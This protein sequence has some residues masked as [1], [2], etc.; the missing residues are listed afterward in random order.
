MQVEV[1]LPNSDGAL[2]PGAYVQVVAAAAGEPGAD[3]SRPTRC[4]S[5]AKARASRSSTPTA[6]VHLRPVTL[7]RNYGE[8]VEVLDGVDGERPAR[9]QPA[10]L[11]RRRRRGRGRRR[12]G[13]APK[14]AQVTRARALRAAPLRSRRCS[15]RAPP[16]PTTSGR[17]STCRWRGRSRRRG[18][19]ARPSDA[20]RKG[21]WWQRFGDPQL[22]ALEQQA[23]AGNPTLA[24]ASARLAQAR[25]TLAVGVGRRCSRRSASAC[26]RRALQDLR[27][28]AAHQLQLAATSRRSR[29]TSSLALDGQLRGRPRR[30]RAAHDRRRARLGRAVGGRP[31]E[32][33]AA[34][35]RRPRDRLL[36]PARDRHRARRAGALDRAAAARARARRPRGTTSA[37][38]RASTSRSS[39]R[40]STTR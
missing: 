31:R 17:R 4:C 15:R 13:A 38:P 24:A 18:A 20:R 22:D 8:T 16:G 25:A 12:R 23:L 36:Q 14:D 2:L 30:P 34:A 21:P 10:R 33:A 32:R 40:C 28:P 11:A 39:R 37:P 27:E 3:R 9:A 19:K 6:R 26:A 7:G 1:A 5:A 29:T 35:D